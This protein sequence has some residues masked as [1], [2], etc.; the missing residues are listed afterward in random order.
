MTYIYSE[1][2]F[3]SVCLY[4]N[5]GLHGL[6]ISHKTDARLIWVKMVLG[7]MRDVTFTIIS[8]DQTVTNGVV[9]YLSRPE[10]VKLFSSSTQLSMKFILHINVKMPTIVG[11]LTSI[12]RINI[13][14]ES[15]KA[16]KIFIFQHFT[17]HKQL[18]CLI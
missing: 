13:A 18:I 8:L 9:H 15:F 4:I 14:S 17:F 11:I 7:S 10:V 1:A 12:S 16:R 2:A 3:C 6:P 5:L